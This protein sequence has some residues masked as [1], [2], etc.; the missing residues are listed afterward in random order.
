[1]DKSTFSSALLFFMQHIGQLISEELTRQERTPAWLAC[2]LGC[3]RTNAYKILKRSSIDTALLMRICRVLRH[4]FFLDLS[5]SARSCD[6]PA[7]E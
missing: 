5:A 1:M 6:K 7:T 2:K 4:D 3:D